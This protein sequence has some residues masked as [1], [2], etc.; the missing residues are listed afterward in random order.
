MEFA[1]G[2]RST[3]SKCGRLETLQGLALILFHQH[4][5]YGRWQLGMSD[6]PGCSDCYVNETEGPRKEKVVKSGNWESVL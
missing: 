6:I 3:V 2:C 1:A 4:C 5:G